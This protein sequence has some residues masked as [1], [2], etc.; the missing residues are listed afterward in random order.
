M[1]CDP[2]TCMLLHLLLSWSSLHEEMKIRPHQRCRGDSLAVDA[3]GQ[4]CQTGTASAGRGRAFS[5]A[6]DC[7]NLHILQIAQNR[8]NGPFQPHMAATLA[9]L[10]ANFGQQ[11]PNFEM[12]HLD[13]L[14]TSAQRL[15]DGGP[16]WEQLRPKLR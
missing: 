8:P 13:H 11:G 1:V 15:Q 14:A 12:A 5:N 9:R 3:T 6:Q 2:S 10:G 7:G 16:I 4:I